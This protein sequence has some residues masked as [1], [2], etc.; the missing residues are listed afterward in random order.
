MSIIKTL[1]KKAAEVRDNA[2]E[3]IVQ[4][5]DVFMYGLGIVVGASA[6]AVIMGVHKDL[7]FTGI[8]ENLNDKV[9]YKESLTVYPC[10]NNNTQQ[11]GLAVAGKN[12]FGEI[13]SEFI[14]DDANNVAGF[15]KELNNMAKKAGATVD[16]I[17]DGKEY[18]IV[19]DDLQGVVREMITAFENV[20]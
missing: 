14:F 2:A 6:G 12:L 9:I 4:N 17:K 1:K 13:T 19:P 7:K 5:E 10:F 3:W 11:A 8:L 16:V 20:K 18:A 15:S